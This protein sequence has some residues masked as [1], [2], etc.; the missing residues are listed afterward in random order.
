MTLAGPRVHVLVFD[1]L[2]DWE[3]GYALAEVRRSGGLEVVS[4]GFTAEPVTTMG[5][6]RILPDLA[7][8]AVMPQD[9]RLLVLPGGELWE[10]EY[11]RAALEPVLHELAAAGTPL[12]A[13][14]GATLALALAGL[15]DERR[16]TSNMLD[17]LVQHAPKYRG[18]RH[19][20]TDLAVRDRGV[21]TAS[22]LGSV[23]FAR[24]IFAELGVF[25]DADRSLW[26]D[27]FKFGT[28]PPMSGD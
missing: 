9:V 28:L 12:A 20:V 22:G 3:A 10:G 21:I 19:Y 13:I 24:E 23:E 5:G 6:L 17:Y 25:S 7:L 16:H 26:F 18:Q 11:P 2:A 4:V 8:T 1:G 14:C 27:A 15:L